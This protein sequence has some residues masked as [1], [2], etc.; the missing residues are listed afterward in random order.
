MLGL[1]TREIAEAENRRRQLETEVVRTRQRIEAIY[2]FLAKS[3]RAHN[4]RDR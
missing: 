1:T 3:R 4:S 2:S